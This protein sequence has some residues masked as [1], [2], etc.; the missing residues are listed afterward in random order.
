[1]KKQMI[2]GIMMALGIVA[3][4][5]L[6]ASAAGTCGK[7][8]D[9]QAV[10]NYQQESYSLSQ[11]VA[12]KNAELRELYLLETIDLGKADVIEEEL[13]ELKGRI[14]NVADKY[15]IPACSRS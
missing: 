8:A 1:M 7:C 15:G 12:A 9:N 3:F 14:G 6:S 2:V 4:G 10:Q 11:A 13:K 5:A